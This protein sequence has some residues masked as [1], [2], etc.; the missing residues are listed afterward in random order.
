MNLPN[1]PG[2]DDNDPTGN[3]PVVNLG[4]T[5]VFNNPVDCNVANAIGY[6]P[7]GLIQVVAALI[8]LNSPSENHTFNRYHAMQSLVFAGVA[9][10]LMVAVSIVISIIGAIPL[11]GPLIAVPLGMIVPFLLWAAYGLISLKMVYETFL[12]HNYRLPYL[13]KYVDQM[14]RD[15]R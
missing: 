1:R 7:L 5:S 12:G 9:L 14:L 4:K 3:P 11:I 8:L 13:A 2:A 6:L 10:L 15:A